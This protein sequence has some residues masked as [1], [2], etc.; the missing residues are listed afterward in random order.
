MGGK[1]I[2]ISEKKSMLPYCVSKMKKSHSFDGFAMLPKAK[3][4]HHLE[5]NC[6][7][8]WRIVPG[9]GDFGRCY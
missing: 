9:N 6:S 3:K 2:E 7:F 4:E 8:L 1:L 5:D